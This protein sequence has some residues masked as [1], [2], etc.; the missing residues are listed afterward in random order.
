[1]SKHSHDAILPAFTAFS[2]L[3]PPQKSVTINTKDCLYKLVRV[4]AIILV[5]KRVARARVTVGGAQATASTSHTIAVFNRDL[6]PI[7]AVSVAIE[8]HGAP[9]TR[10]PYADSFATARRAISRQSM[11]LPFGFCKR[12]G[13]HGRVELPGFDTA[14]ISAPNSRSSEAARANSIWLWSPKPALKK[15][16]LSKM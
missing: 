10:S 7:V 5:S 1:M 6:L 16:P 2:A 11:P 8:Y 12:S 15:T 3:V 14:A 9:S 4:Y 13:G